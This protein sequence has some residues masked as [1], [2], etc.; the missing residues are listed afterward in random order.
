M[1]TKAP[2]IL[3]IVNPKA[4]RSGAPEAA[5]RFC[6]ELRRL[7]ARVQELHTGARGDAR[8]FAFEH[9]A[10]FD[11]LVAAGGDGTFSEMVSGLM[12]LEERPDVGFLPVGSTCDIA[13]TFNLPADPEEAAQAM[14]EG[15]SYPIDVG[16]ISGSPPLLRGDLPEEAIP[17]DTDLLPDHFTYIASFGAF[18]ET[19]YATRR[20]MKKTLGHLAYVLQGI[21]SVPGI[22]PVRAEVILDGQDYSGS[23]IFGGVINSF[24]VGGMVRIDDVDLN[25]GEFEVILIKPPHN[26]G[27][28]A[29]LLSHLVRRKT[30]DVIVKKRAR[31]ILFR[32]EA[33]LSFTADGEYGGS[34]K[35]WQIEN[36]R[37]AVR[38]RV[39]QP[40]PK[41]P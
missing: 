19:S 10:S 20:R 17:E 5:T 27:Q 9:A 29:R 24:S 16:R 26:V 40:P 1:N 2:S 38:L 35:E 23:Y 36:I 12:G 7:G 34:R 25:D 37:R 18:S 3:V 32:F 11:L 14:L 8:D 13:R 41:T 6:T 39:C 28:I 15:I 33:P 31:E 21:S 22:H 4:G 30:G